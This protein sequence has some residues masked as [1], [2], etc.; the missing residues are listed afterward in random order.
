MIGDILFCGNLGTEGGTLWLLTGHS[1][2]ASYQ[3]DVGHSQGTAVETA[4]Q[5]PRP[6]VLVQQSVQ[7]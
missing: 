2:V 5:R 4:V 6:D 7:W 3:G 1:G